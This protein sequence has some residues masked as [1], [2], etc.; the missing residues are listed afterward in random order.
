M[1]FKSQAVTTSL[2]FP[3]AYAGKEM[4][5]DINFTCSNLSY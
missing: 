1:P 3:A 2:Q 5:I 4:Y